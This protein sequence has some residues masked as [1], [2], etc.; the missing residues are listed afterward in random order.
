[1]ITKISIN[2]T[3]AIRMHKTCFLLTSAP[4]FGNGIGILLPVIKQIDMSEFLS[5]IRPLEWFST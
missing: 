1:M 2:A 4:V 3:T 5:M